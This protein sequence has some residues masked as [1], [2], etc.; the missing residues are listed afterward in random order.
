MLGSF[1]RS[2]DPGHH[3]SKDQGTRD[4]TENFPSF[5]T[6]PRVLSSVRKDRWSYS[7]LKD[8]QIV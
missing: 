2:L 3:S 5:L 7:C 1:E 8:D 6:L 4:L